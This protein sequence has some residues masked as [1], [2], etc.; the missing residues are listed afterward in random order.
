MWIANCGGQ[1]LPR[2][3]EQDRL[4]EQTHIELRGEAELKAC[5]QLIAYRID[6]ATDN[7]SIGGRLGYPKGTAIRG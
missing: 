6:S 4:N 5:Q 3:R 7:P 2:W 1:K